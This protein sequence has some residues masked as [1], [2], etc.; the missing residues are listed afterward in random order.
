MSFGTLGGVPFRIDPDSISWTYQPKTSATMT[1]G[2]KV[3]QVYGSVVSDITVRGQFGNRNSDGP[4][5]SWMEQ[6]RFL[7]LVEGWVDQQIGNMSGLAGIPGAAGQG[8]QNGQPIR[9]TFPP[10]NFDFQVYITDFVEPGSPYS[11]QQDAST[12]NHSWQ[13]S[14]FVYQNNGSPNPADPATNSSLI[15][16]IQR[17]SKVF[18][19]FPTKYSGPVSDNQFPTLNQQGG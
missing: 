19:W 6:A 18:G 9:F 11:S 10:L 2:G 5:N 7:N 12:F 3:V 15:E 1:V 14:L 16:H 8:L 4:G 13:L 17:V